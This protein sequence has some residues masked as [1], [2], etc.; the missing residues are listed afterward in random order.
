MM[1][2][3]TAELSGLFAKSH[4]LESEIRANLK[5]IGYEVK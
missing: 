5:S 3:L 1:K 2:R 4:D